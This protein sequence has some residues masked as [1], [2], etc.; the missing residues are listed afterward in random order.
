[1]GN[2]TLWL[3]SAIAVAALS[4]LA[5]PKS[6]VADTYTIYNLGNADATSVYGID[7]AGD[8]V[9]RDSNC[10]D[11]LAPCFV[12]YHLGV[13]ISDTVTAPSLAYDDGSSCGSSLSGFNTIHLICNDGH[14]GFGSLSNPNGNSSG[15]Y[16][17]ASGD[18]QRIGSIVDNDV[19]DAFGD[20][21]WTAG[22]SEW[23]YEAYDDTTHDCD[24]APVPE[25]STLLLIGSGL[26]FLTGTLRRRFHTN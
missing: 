18:L 1:M 8:V 17:G 24:P 6:A 12:T 19:L 2:S 14:V 3:R 7:D 9:T 10:G 23:L 5:S 21:A 15:A 16:T 13:A 22:N 11:P 26:I 25:P 4:L 20:F